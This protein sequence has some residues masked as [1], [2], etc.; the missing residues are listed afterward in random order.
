MK[1]VFGKGRKE[2]A[3]VLLISLAV[4]F[5]IG[6]GLASYLTMAQSQNRLVAQSQ[7][8]N[9]ALTLAE[10]GIEEGMGQI[11]A[12][13]G[14]N[15]LPSA[16]TNWGMISGVYGPRTNYMTNGSYSAI[17]T[18]ASPGPIITAMGYTVVPANNRPVQRTVRVTTTNVPAF[19]VAMMVKLDIDSKG[20]DMMVDSYDSSDPLH[21]TNGMYNAATRKAS[22]D[23]VSSGGVINVQNANIYG[24]LWTSPSGS[25]TIGANGTVGDLSWN[26]KGQVQPGY[27]KND[28]NANIK[29]VPVPFTSGFSVTAL[30]SGT[31]TYVLGTGDY[32]VSGDFV[33]NQNENVYVNG[34]ARMYVTG[35]INMKSQNDC[36]FNIAPGA[37]LKLYCG[38]PSGAA[39]SAQMTQV[40]TAGNASTF[41]YWGLPSNTSVTWNGNNTYV[42]T[43][44]A[45]QAAFSMGGG[46]STDFDFQGSCVVNTVSMNG[47]FLFHYDEN[48]SRMGPP[49]GFTVT[50]WREL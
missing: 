14:T 20:N 12:V 32:Y 38:T 17:I 37:S 9:T 34:N 41:Q 43:V 22:G 5:I 40:N 39:V 7:A 6:L 2:A 15:Y 36:Y 29:D 30:S 4:L 11:N 27:Y 13:F 1:I 24:H 28:F 3:S 35:N 16:Q 18:P 48:L 46:G 44:Y 31:N 25:Y 47:H 45:P 8:W 10:E 19:G 42:G 50:S 23:L 33:L 26:T 49:T 21:S